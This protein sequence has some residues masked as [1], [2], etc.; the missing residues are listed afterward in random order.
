ML[1]YQPMFFL[2][3]E[4]AKKAAAKPLGAVAK[5]GLKK[6]KQE[7]SSDGSSSDDE[8]DDDVVSGTFMFVC[9]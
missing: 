6:G 9:L 2:I 8:S 5:N 3:Q 1:S 4:P 7:S